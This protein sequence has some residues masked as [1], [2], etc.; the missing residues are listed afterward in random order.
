M[1]RENSDNRGVRSLDGMTFQS[2]SMSVWGWEAAKQNDGAFVK[3]SKKFKNVW[4]KIFRKIAELN[5]F[6]RMISKKI[7]IIK[8]NVKNQNFQSKFSVEN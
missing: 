4:K 6:E 7:A 2:A 1:I 5:E 8:I 3:L